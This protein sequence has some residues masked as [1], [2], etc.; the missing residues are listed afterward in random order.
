MGKHFPPA[1]P[2]K[3]FY[4]IGVAGQ[5]WGEAE[6]ALWAAKAGVVKRSYS[7]EVLA[8]LEF[9]K[10]SFDVEQYGAL[11]QD[12]ARYP[13]FCIKTRDWDTAK[14]CVLVTGGVHGYELSG[15][16]GALLFAQTEMPKYASEFNVVVC[17][18]VSPW[19]YE[20]IQRWSAR[21]VDPNRSIRAAAADCPTEETAALVSLIESLG[22]RGAD[23]WRMHMDCHETTD[24][25]VTE[26]QPARS[27]RD[28]EQLDDE[29]IPDGFYLV[30]DAEKPQTAWHEA[31]IDR[32]R[33]VTH[34]APPDNEG[35]ICELP[36]VADGII[37]VPVQKLNLCSSVT[38]ATFAT[39]TEVYP[40]SGQNRSASLPDGAAVHS[41]VTSDQCNRAQVAAVTAGLDF[42]VQQMLKNGSGWPGPGLAVE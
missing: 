5:P 12:P 26:F 14:P 33:A 24:T 18:C 11:S 28:G 36:V 30:G 39:T 32:V 9:L 1:N 27:S 21:G 34:I 37:V 15:V 40:D 8:K 41:S 29:G 4:P 20:C 7:E 3:H 23:R 42:I 13:L 17:P 25:D 31:I 35:N 38:G 2:A 19:G 16:Q 10:E 6:F 22:G